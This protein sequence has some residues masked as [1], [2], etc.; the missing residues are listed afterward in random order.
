MNTKK[1]EL[2]FKWREKKF[3][4]VQQDQS[5][6]DS[7]EEENDTIVSLVKEKHG[8]FSFVINEMRERRKKTDFISLVLLIVIIRLSYFTL[9]FCLAS[10]HTHTFTRSGKKKLSHPEIGK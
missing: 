7:I 3:G 4:N 6:Y 2:L 1:M 8:A 9:Q 10:T 5:K